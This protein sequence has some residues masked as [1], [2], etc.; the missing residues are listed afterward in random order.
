MTGNGRRGRAVGQRYSIADRPFRGVLAPAREGAE[1]TTGTGEPETELR[2]LHK[3]TS[4]LGGAI[5]RISVSLD[6]ATIPQEAL[7]STRALTVARYGI[8]ATID[9][10]G[11][12]TCRESRADRWPS[13]F[14]ATADIADSRGK[15]TVATALNVA[16]VRQVHA[17]SATSRSGVNRRGKRP[18][19]LTSLP[20]VGFPQVLHRAAIGNR[21]GFHSQ[22]FQ[23]KQQ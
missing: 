14:P 19:N 13:S 1:P 11:A 5:L 4:G 7:D 6:V 16:N 21:T 20:V 22:N 10:T 2:E 23:W 12:A 3:R 17:R 18:N 8:M 15:R 9:E